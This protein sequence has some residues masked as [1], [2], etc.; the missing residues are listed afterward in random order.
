[1]LLEEDTQLF[2]CSSALA[3]FCDLNLTLVASLP[4]TPLNP[5]MPEKGIASEMIF[6]EK[7]LPMLS[8]WKLGR[9]VRP[10][11]VK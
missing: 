2:A 11:F 1:M 9:F 8:D 5:E 4:V 7:S 3:V 6:I 10:N